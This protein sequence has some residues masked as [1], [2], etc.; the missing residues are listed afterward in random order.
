MQGLYKY[1]PPF[2]SDIAGVC[3]AL[4]GLGGI[5]VIH[6]PAC[7]TC[8]YTM[9]DEP[10]YYGSSSALYSSELR[11]IHL[12]TGDDETILRRIEAAVY[13]MD[14]RFIAI[15][16]SPIPMF[17]G[18]DYHALARI[19]EKRT[20][21]PSFAVDA[22]GFDWYDI[23]ASK[24]FIAI[25]KHFLTA[26]YP[27][28]EKEPAV[29][30]IGSTP[31]D[32]MATNNRDGLRAIIEESDYQILSFWTEGSSIEEIAQSAKASVNIVVSSSGIQTA[33][34]LKDTFGTPYIL[35]LPIG[36]LSSMLFLKKL[37]TE[38]IYPE[39]GPAC[40]INH[41]NPEDQTS[42]LIIGDQVISNSIRDCLRMDFG[43]R[44]VTVASF[45]SMGNSNLEVQDQQMHDED[46][47][48]EL[49]DKCRFDVIMGDKVFSK[50]VNPSIGIRFVSIPQIAVSGFSPFE[51]IPDLSGNNGFSYFN[52]ILYDL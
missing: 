16:G 14:C 17:A 5:V 51:E 28:P 52:E 25:A 31:L 33:E 8:S 48:L 46:S 18:T 37:K 13:Q 30:I 39:V 10:R 20:G 4:F 36:Q 32:G 41:T 2:S 23:G 24:A 35:G 6:E 44:N 26:P 42:V 9:F 27:L 12:A 38:M 49:L 50:I 22:G 40:A 3:S 47:L 15:V 34:Y 19:A 11:E 1:L 45:F 29:N 43:I 21:I 7:C